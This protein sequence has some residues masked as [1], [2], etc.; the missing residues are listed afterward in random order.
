MPSMTG[1]S[2][3]IN[4]DVKAHLRELSRLNRNWIKSGCW[5]I[6]TTT[7]NDDGTTT[8]VE[9]PV[10]LEKRPKQTQSK[11]HLGHMPDSAIIG[12]KIV[13]KPGTKERVEAIKR[14]YEQGIDPF[15]VEYEHE[16]N[17]LAAILGADP[18]TNTNRDSIVERLYSCN[19][20]EPDLSIG[21]DV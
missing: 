13:G 11:R 9:R 2:V 16:V 4:K 19:S 17:A 21:Q 10:K 6:E 12:V 5:Y 15:T 18:R 3:K 14:S 8:I 20:D 1:K 7:T